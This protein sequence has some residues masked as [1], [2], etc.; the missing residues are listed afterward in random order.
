MRATYPS[1]IERQWA[2]CIK[3]L[4]QIRRQTVVAIGRMSQFVLN[5]EGSLIPV[6]LGAVVDRRRVDR[7]H[8]RV[9]FES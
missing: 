3:V 7:P 1:S 4:G 6:P 5:T 8:D 9:R 2:E